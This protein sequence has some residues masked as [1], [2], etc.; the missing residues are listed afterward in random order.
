MKKILELFE[1]TKVRITLISILVALFVIVMMVSIQRNKKKEEQKP[2]E[3]TNIV[4]NDDVKA[5]LKD[6]I[7]ELSSGYYCEFP[8]NKEY[9]NDCIYRNNKTV[10]ANL[11]V[12]YR[13]YSLIMAIGSKSSNNIMVGNIVV[14]GKS[15][16]NPHY[17]NLIDVEKEYK[18]LYGENETF[19]PNTINEINTHVIKYDS[20][21]EK[22]FYQEPETTAFIKTYIESYESTPEEVSVQVRVGYI[23]YEMYRYH[24]YND[25]NKSREITTLTTREYRENGI[26]NDT[27]YIE[28]AKYRAIFMKEENSDNLIFKSIELVS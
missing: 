17:V 8:T 23:T 15:M 10:R 3:P 18:K 13:V 27:N 7:N 16:N 28:L 12:T 11:T 6:Y 4:I 25:K 24:L 2:T 21:K 26:I 22:Y 14:D 20:S 9:T 5:Q 19:E 1:D